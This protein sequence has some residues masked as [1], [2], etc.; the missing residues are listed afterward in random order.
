MRVGDSCGGGM[1]ELRHVGCVE[2]FLHRLGSVRRRFSFCFD[3]LM[4]ALRMIR[5]VLP[6]GIS[7][8]DLWLP[9]RMCCFLDWKTI[10]IETKLWI[11]MLRPG[12]LV[13]VGI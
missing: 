7:W 8:V 12:Q 10:F 2:R 6:F 1:V 5:C 13:E 3:V 4:A 9:V 11:R